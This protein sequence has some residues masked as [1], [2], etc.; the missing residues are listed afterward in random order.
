MVSATISLENKQN[1]PQHTN[2]YRSTDFAKLLS[3]DQDFFNFANQIG[4]CATAKDLVII[5]QFWELMMG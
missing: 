2:N 4:S 3:N 1:Q 5:L